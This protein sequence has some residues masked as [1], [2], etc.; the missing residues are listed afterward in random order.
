[1]KFAV[2]AGDEWLGNV[3]ADD[4]HQALNLAKGAD[5]SATR[6]EL[7]SESDQDSGR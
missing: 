2:Y 6:V 4:E 1:M 5:A 3:H 7:V